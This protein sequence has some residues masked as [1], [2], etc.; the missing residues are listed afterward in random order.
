MFAINS[1]CVMLT[2]SSKGGRLLLV[3]IWL[4]EEICIAL[5]SYSIVTGPSFVQ[6]QK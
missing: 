2:L 6:S 3:V 1:S 5:I 4:T